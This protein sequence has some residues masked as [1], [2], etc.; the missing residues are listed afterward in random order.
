MLFIVHNKREFILNMKIISSLKAK[1]KKLKKEI[2]V[3]YLAYKRKDVPWY[4]K[5]VAIIVVGYAL[6]PIDLI[7][8]FIPILGYVDDLIL[9]PAGVILAIKLIPKDIMDE[10]R[11]Q[12]ENVFKD[13]KPKNWVSGGLIILIW[14]VLIGWILYEFVLKSYIK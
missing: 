13:G 11:Q 8:D 6:S 3:L 1:A 7:P 2:A 12:S 10:C 5:L 14:V 9:V 4:A